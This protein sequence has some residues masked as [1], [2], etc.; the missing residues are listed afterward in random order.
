MEFFADEFSVFIGV[1]GQFV[2]EA[3]GHTFQV[4][5]EVALPVF[6]VFERG[7]CHGTKQVG[8]YRTDKRFSSMVAPERDESRLHDVFDVVIRKQERQSGL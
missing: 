1:G 6:H 8:T 5:E 2:D 7:F 4:C 3:F